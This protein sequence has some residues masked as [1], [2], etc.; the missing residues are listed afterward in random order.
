MAATHAEL[1]ELQELVKDFHTALLTTRGEDGHFHTRPMELQRRSLDEGFWFA[2][3]ENTAKVADIENDEHCGLAL[4]SGERGATYVSISG[5]AHLVRERE[6]IHRM[7]DPSWRPWFPDGPDQADLV[8]IRFDPE[9]A[10]YVHPKTGR[11]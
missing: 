4:F 9:H 3:S 8:L 6:I 5:N 7:W 2:T 1:Q 10:E 11:L